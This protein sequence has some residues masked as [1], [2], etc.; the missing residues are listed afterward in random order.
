MRKRLYLA[1]SLAASSVVTA[2]AGAARGTGT[3]GGEETGEDEA[4]GGGE[5]AG[6]GTVTGGGKRT[7][8]GA[9]TPGGA[10]M[11]EGEFKGLSGVLR[12]PSPMA[13]FSRLEI[14]F[15][16]SVVCWRSSAIS[17]RVGD[18]SF[19]CKSWG[20]NFIKGRDIR[21]AKI[22]LIAFALNCLW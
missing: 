2:G 19:V 13:F 22:D 17:M 15:D 1:R 20:S 6:G 3:T 12:D 18:K 8:V 9:V 21:E 11:L 16:S 5:E 10:T 14:P 4:A 7:D